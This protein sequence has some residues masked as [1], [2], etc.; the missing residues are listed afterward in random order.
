MTGIERSE[1][2]KVF[3]RI[4]GSGSEFALALVT[5]IVSAI[6][7]PAGF[8]LKAASQ[9]PPPAPGPQSVY[10]ASA[11]QSHPQSVYGASAAQLA[12]TASLLGAAASA[13]AAPQARSK[14]D[15]SNR[16]DEKFPV[17]TP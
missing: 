10:G 8:V 11:V 14:L 2:V 13:P 4:E 15:N 3:G 12:A 16:F 1:V 5:S 7:D 6:T 17:D 9:Q